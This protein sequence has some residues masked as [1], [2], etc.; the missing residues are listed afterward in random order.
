MSD[1]YLTLDTF[2]HEFRDRSWVK[3]A[4]CRGMDPSLFF[5]ER[6]ENEK[7]DKAKEICQ[8]CAVRDECAEYGL[9]EQK[10]FWGGTS[11]MARRKLRKER[12]I[13]LDSVV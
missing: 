4:A 1:D 2:L 7:V 6:G 12:G 11:P 13:I 10:G 8:S 3:R 9:Y 5:P